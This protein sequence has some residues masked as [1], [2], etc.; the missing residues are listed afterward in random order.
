MDLADE[1]QAS[2]LDLFTFLSQEAEKTMRRSADLS[3]SHRLPPCCK[4]RRRRVT[5]RFSAGKEEIPMSAA[6]TAAVVF[7]MPSSATALSPRLA[8]DPPMLSSLA[9]AQGSVAMPDELEERLRFYVRQIKSFRRTSLLHPSPELKEKISEMEENYRSA[10]R[11]F[12]CWPP[13]SSCLQKGATAQPRPCLQ[14]HLGSSHRGSGQCLGSVLVDEPRYEGFEDEPLLLLLPPGF[15]RRL[16]RLRGFARHCF[17]EPPGLHRQRP[18]LLV[19][20]CRPLK[21]HVSAGL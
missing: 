19:N 11:Q 12:Y 16:F 17:C 8:V 7:P 2:S 13:P 5:S 4:K 3:L 14:G 15:A 18:R 6:A 9:A 1:P 10:A 21:T 20:R